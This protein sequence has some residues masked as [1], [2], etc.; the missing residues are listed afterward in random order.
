MAIAAHHGAVKANVAALVGRGDLDLSTHELLLGDA[1]LLVEQDHGVQLDSFL[2]VLIINSIRA[3]EEVQLL[4][5]DAVLQGTGVLLGT[6]MG[7]QVGDAEDGIVLVLAHTDGDGGAILTG[8]HAVDGQRDRAPLILA[9]TT[10]VMGLEVAQVVRLIQRGGTQVQTRAVGVGNDQMEAILKALGTDGGSHHSLVALDKVDFVTGLVGLFRVELLVACILEH[11][12]ALGGDLA[13]GLACIQ[14]LL[15]ALGKVVGL[16]LHV[17]VL[18]G[19]V[20][21]L[22][23]QLFSQLLVRSFF[24]HRISP[25]FLFR[26]S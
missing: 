22:I 17:S 11:L 18:I 15:V 14:E 12:L 25:A 2:D 8:E 3:D 1:V 24:C 21:R 26:Y 4:S 10:V 19:D 7:Q 20:S 9:D 13:L 6:Q 5:L 23:E 16:L